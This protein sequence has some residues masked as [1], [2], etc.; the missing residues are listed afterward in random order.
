MAVT[1]VKELRNRERAPKVVRVEGSTGYAE[2]L[3]LNQTLGERDAVE[4]C[5]VEG[6]LG[7][8]ACSGADNGLSELFALIETALSN[9]VDMIGYYDG[10]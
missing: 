6:T 8:N 7:N 1:E 3:N 5:A 9:G 2:L 10:S 4:S